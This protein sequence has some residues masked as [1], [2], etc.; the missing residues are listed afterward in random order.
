VSAR[1]RIPRPVLAV[2]ACL[3]LTL[4][5]TVALGAVQRPADA[6]SDLV[7][8]GRELYRTGCISCHGTDGAGVKGPEGDV[9][10]P[11]ILHAGEA[12]AY[13][14]LSTGRMPLANSSDDPVR[15]PPAYSPGEIRA[16]VAYVAS[17]GD[18]PPLPDVHV[19][20]D[21][22]AGGELFRANCQA[23]H[24]AAGAGGALSYGRAAPALHSA[25]PEQIAAAVR[26]GP[27]QMPV[28]GETEID[29]HQL[30]QLTTYVRYLREPED[31]GGFPIGRIGPIPEGFVA[32]SVGVV[33]LLGLVFWIGTRSPI[34]RR[35][36]P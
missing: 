5:V 7:A 32:W 16:L 11:S 26:S 10:G 14:Q 31:P 25:T 24:S 8:Q 36:D 6:Q 18:G 27:G 17:L 21:V 28:F 29:Q 33:A 4:G 9:R 35:D 15:K 20:A 2:A 13:Y 1:R 30:D 22:A 3:G 34:R 19:G 12:G 23:C